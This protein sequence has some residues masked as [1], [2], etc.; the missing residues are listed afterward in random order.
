MARTVRGKSE[1][2]N[3]MKT[4]SSK[5]HHGQ[6]QGELATELMEN[7]KPG[8]ETKKTMGLEREMAQRLRAPPALLEVL[9]SIP[10]IHMMAHKHL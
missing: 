2:S 5:T 8:A 6:T 4:S 10:S 9:N 3:T 7:Q 1:W